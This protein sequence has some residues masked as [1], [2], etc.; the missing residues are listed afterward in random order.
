MAEIRVFSG[1]LFGIFFK[2]ALTF[3]LSCPSFRPFQHI[4]YGTSR[5]SPNIVKRGAITITSVFYQDI[6]RTVKAENRKSGLY[7][8]KILTQAYNIGR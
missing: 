8:D 1:G 5:I 6:S 4:I 7:W 3:I 2:I